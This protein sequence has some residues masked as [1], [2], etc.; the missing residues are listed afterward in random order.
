MGAGFDLTGS[1]RGPLASFF[2]ATLVVLM[3]R[4]GPYRYRAGEPDENDQIVHVQAKDR[5]CGA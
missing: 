5:P 1:Y 4:L 2:A 3:T